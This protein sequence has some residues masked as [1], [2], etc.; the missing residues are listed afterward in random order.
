MS[1]IIHHSKSEEYAS[2]A[3][4]TLKQGDAETATKL[5][6]RAAEEEVIALTKLDPSKVR[7]FGVTVVSAASLWF[8]AH[9]LRQAERVA[10]Q[11]LATD[12][13]P[14]FAIDQLQTILQ[15]VWN[16]KI[17]QQ[18]GIEFM[19]GEVLVS[20][21]GGEVVTGGAPLDLILRKV[22][23]V[24]SLFYRTIEM[25]LNLPF[26]RRGVPSLDLQQRFRPWLLQA[27]PGSYQFA[28]RVQ[29]PAQMS[30]FPDATPEVEEVTRAF[31]RIVEATAKE[32][33][34]DLEN[35]VP[36]REYR[37]AFLKLSRNLAPTGKSFNRLEIKSAT[38]TEARPIVFS[39]TSR[40]A[41]NK[42]LRETKKPPEEQAELKEEQLT[43]VLRA[44]HLDQDWLELSFPGTNRENIR[45]YQT[46]DVIDDLV[47]PMVNHRVILDVALH[48]DGKHV[49]RD[50]QSEE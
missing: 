31:L 36:N 7:T 35:A 18:S 50:I 44:L 41:I 21:G 34:E 37:E 39:P 9:D 8:K 16:E 26:R 23:E 28:V 10:C 47:G 49:F 22:D 12:L 43:G 3:E 30:L 1:W 29:K 20:V 46:G 5:Y 48:P 2:Q 38:D 6:R 45:V 25:L 13:L 11:W 42:T 27:P 15:S 4:T 24:R 17:Y 14:D 33:H 19:K 32:T 40:Q